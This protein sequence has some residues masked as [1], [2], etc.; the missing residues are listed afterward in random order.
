[1]G[2]VLG[3]TAGMARLF[4]FNTLMSMAAL[5]LAASAATAAPAG[6]SPYFGRWTVS[7]DKPVYTAKGREY[8]TIDIAPCGPKGRPTN[9]C[10]V[11]VGDKGQCGA[12]LFRFLMSSAQ[13]FGLGGR[14]KWGHAYLHLK[15]IGGDSD[16]KELDLGLGDNGYEMNS[17]SGSMPKFQATYRRLGNATC[18][19]H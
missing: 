4:H 9:F 1:M 16:W 19:A 7:D 10:G 8:K 15:I 5:A 6:T 3:E 11:S 17:R 18:H 13:K 12:V 2:R 14:G